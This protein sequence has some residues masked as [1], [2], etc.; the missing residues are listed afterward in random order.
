M[1][2]RCA[3]SSYLLPPYPQLALLACSE[4]TQIRAMV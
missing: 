2:N 4:D 1:I 3:V